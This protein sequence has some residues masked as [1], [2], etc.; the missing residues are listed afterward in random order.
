MGAQEV[1]RLALH[2][3]HAGVWSG[4][5]PGAGPGLV[6]GLRAHGP[7][8]PQQGH[9]FNPHKV[10]LD[11]WARE[12]VGRFA[13]DDAHFDHVRDTP[14]PL[15]ADVR[16]NAPIALKARVPQPLAAV[17]RPGAP[18]REARDI[19]LYEVHV[20]GATMQLPGVPPALRG[21]YLGLS[22]P[23]MRAHLRALGVTTL[24]LL[25]VHFH[26]DEEGL[27]ARGAVNHWGYNTLGFFCA[28][29]RLA[30]AP[31]RE[32]V[33]SAAANA[34]FREMV[35][36]LHADG[37]EVVIDVVFNHTAEAGET[38]PT[39][40]FRG[41]DHASWY[42]LLPDDPSRC[43]NLSGCGN[44]LNVAHP[45]VTQF[46]LDALRHWVQVMG[47]DG[48]RFDLAPVL[49]R[50]DQGYDPRAAFFTAL[51]QDPVLAHTRLI[52]EPWDA[53][54][55]GYQLGRFPGAGWNG[56]TSSATPRA[57]T[58]WT[59]ASD[60]ASSRAASPPRATCST[61]ASVCRRPVSTSSP[62]TTASRWPT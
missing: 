19:V 8:A 16:D 31:A 59:A 25:P 38:G 53:G 1:R 29:P 52:A 14:G 17:A 41:L 32:A 4:F 55:A 62:R 20:R 45:R 40:S 58:G 15:L 51:Q 33:D 49:G 57:A 36:E 26:L 46:V 9:R 47:V 54:H 61:T 24:S 22:H 7:W 43:E 48:F 2:G 23:A 39:V 30:S 56:T 44:T 11:P 6:Y 28:D 27:A 18:R 35:D 42:R 60:A 21:S 34:E 10:L 37:F 13:W 5:L 12:I 3:P 50:G